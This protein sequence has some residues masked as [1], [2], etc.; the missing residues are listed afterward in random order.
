[1]AR[2]EAGLEAAGEADWGVLLRSLGGVDSSPRRRQ[3][4]ACFLSGSEGWQEALNQLGGTFAEQK[5]EMR[6]G[7]KE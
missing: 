6:G 4:I 3:A 1:M 2:Y 5:P 7:P